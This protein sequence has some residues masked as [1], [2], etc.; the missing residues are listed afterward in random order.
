[1]E[2]FT[3]DVLHILELL[4]LKDK[5][6]YE[7]RNVKSQAYVKTIDYYRTLLEEVDTD[8]LERFLQRYEM[9]FRLFGYDIEMF[10]SLVKEKRSPQK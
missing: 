3:R 1:M 4:G 9:D 5:I 2:T 6:H 7:A 10:Y 8:N